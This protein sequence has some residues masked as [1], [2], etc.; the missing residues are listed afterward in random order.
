[1]DWTSTV[2]QFQPFPYSD[3]RC[4][5]FNAFTHAYFFIDCQMWYGACT[6]WKGC[7][8][9]HSRCKLQNILCI[10]WQFCH[11]KKRW[12]LFL[13]G[14]LIHYGILRLLG[15]CGATEELFIFHRTGTSLRNVIIFILSDALWDGPFLYLVTQFDKCNAGTCT[16]DN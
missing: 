8:N 11:K 16:V 13:F 7:S 6:C 14:E 3:A 12:M 10:Y 5:D 1:M 2:Q 9:C 4:C 15:I